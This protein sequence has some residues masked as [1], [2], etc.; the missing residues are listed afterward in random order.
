LKWDSFCGYENKKK[1]NKTGLNKCEFQSTSP[2]STVAVRLTVRPPPCNTELC[3]H[4]RRCGN[5]NQYFRG[6]YISRYSEEI[7]VY[8]VWGVGR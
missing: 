6:S 7:N 3:V 8:I 4:G 5:L 2:L 1:L